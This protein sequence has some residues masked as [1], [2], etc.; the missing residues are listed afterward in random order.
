MARL[1]VVSDTRADVAVEIAEG[2]ESDYRGTCN[3]G[4]FAEEPGA[5]GATALRDVIEA[6]KFHLDVHGS[7]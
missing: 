7:L 4:W 3:C 1:L 5:E 2:T 6:A